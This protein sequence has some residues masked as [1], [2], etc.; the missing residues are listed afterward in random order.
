[1]NPLL[2]IKDAAEM[3]KVSESTIYRYCG[4]GRIPFIRK[5]FGIRFKLDALR[6]WI[7][8][9][10]NNM[11]FDRRFLINSLTSLP[12]FDKYESK[13]G[14]EVA[15]TKKVA[16]VMRMEVFIRGKTEGAGRMISGLPRESESKG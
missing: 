4:Q 11:F 5:R 12:P 13:G 6:S 10:S 7:E 3:L 16:D 1:M 15:T 8:L 9:D 14:L 2:T